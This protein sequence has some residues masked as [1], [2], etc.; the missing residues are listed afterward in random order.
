MA[1]DDSA[2]R[3]D[4]EAERLRRLLAEANKRAEAALQNKKNRLAALEKDHRRAMAA[5]V[6]DHGEE[7][8]Q[9]S[10]R[11]DLTDARAMAQAR[12]AEL[13]LSDKRA[14]ADELRTD[15][16]SYADALAALQRALGAERAAHGASVRRQQAELD[17][18]R[19]G[20]RVAARGDGRRPAPRRRGRQAARR[21]ATGRRRDRHGRV[22]HARP[23]REG[24]SC[25][26]R[27]WRTRWAA[28][29][30]TGGAPAR[31]ARR[32]AVDEP[33]DGFPQSGSHRRRAVRL[34]D[35]LI[36]ALPTVFHAEVRSVAPPS[37]TRS[38]S[39]HLLS[40]WV[41]PRP[42]KG[43][44]STAQTPVQHVRVLDEQHGRGRKRRLITPSGT[45]KRARVRPPGRHRPLFPMGAAPSLC[46]MVSPIAN[47]MVPTRMSERVE[48]DG[49]VCFGDQNQ[50]ARHTTTT[51]KHAHRQEI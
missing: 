40:H 1:E 28:R 42:R 36:V 50:R 18:K 16:A 8:V 30:Y 14:A 38:P 31:A 32:D 7:P 45:S 17:A 49:L 19:V 44:R 4:D 37:S 3:L 26:A 33:R 20:A 10:V 15:C 29:A 27:E 34:C 46:S 12:R 13:V 39:Q 6:V 24:S 23:G 5:V 43:D 25:G 9:A 35:Q 22:A 2:R 11:D 51:S 48:A 47:P 21:A 41:Q